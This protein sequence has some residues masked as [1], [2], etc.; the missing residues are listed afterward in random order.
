M[1]CLLQGHKNSG[2]FQVSFLPHFSG[3]LRGIANVSPVIC[4]DLSPAGSY[5]ASGSGDY[6]A[7]ICMS[8]VV[9]QY[10]FFKR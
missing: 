1:Q 9:L 4:A 6:Q 2:E 10:L 7:R 5:L 3:V 8:P